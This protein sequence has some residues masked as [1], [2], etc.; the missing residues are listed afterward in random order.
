M[1]EEGLEEDI[2]KIMKD[3]NLDGVQIRMRNEGPS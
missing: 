1:R 2:R 3:V